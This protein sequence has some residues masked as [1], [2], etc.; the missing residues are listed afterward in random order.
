[1]Q[2]SKGNV[3]DFDLTFSRIAMKDMLRVR[4]SRAVVE[5]IFEMGFENSAEK[6]YKVFP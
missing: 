1:M 5:E 2:N 3:L 6:R 4:G